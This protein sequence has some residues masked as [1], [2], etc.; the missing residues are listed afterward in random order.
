MVLFLVIIGF[1]R[2]SSNFIWRRLVKSMHAHDFLFRDGDCLPVHDAVGRFDSDDSRMVSDFSPFRFRRPI[3][4]LFLLSPIGRDG[5]L[6]A[7]R[8]PLRLGGY[9]PF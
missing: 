3:L 6:V 9:D 4:V 1:S 8:H 7:L 5:G 2:H